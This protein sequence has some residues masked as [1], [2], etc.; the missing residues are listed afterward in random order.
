MLH[1]DD[2]NISNQIVKYAIIQVIATDDF[3]EP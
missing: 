2:L 1:P 3:R